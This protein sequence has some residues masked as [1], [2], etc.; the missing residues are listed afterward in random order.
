MADLAE[1][2]KRQA[3]AAQLA[4]RMAQEQDPDRI[5][6]M[7]AEMQRRAAEIEKMGRALEAALTPAQPAGGSVEVTLTKD[8]KERVTVQTGVGLEKVTLRDSDGRVW[9]RDLAVGRAG[10]RE[11]EKEAAKEAAR[12]RLI[13]D[14][15]RQVEA[16]AAQLESLDVPEISSAIAELRRDPTLGR[17]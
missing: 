3:E 9:S 10:P 7:A 2:Q 15:R 8:Q 6:A 13:A 17:G 5:L 11:V 4:A 14:T 12:L 1:L 16:I